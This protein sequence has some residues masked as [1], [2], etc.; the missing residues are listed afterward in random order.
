MTDTTP[1][2]S[3]RHSLDERESTKN[4]E[5]C[6]VP[7]KARVDMQPPAGARCGGA[8]AGPVRPGREY[9]VPAPGASRGA[10]SP[11][12]SRPVSNEPGSQP[13]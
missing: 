6:E 10:L 13:P 11:E 2:T 9:T 8:T 4:N 5:L 1:H 3:D 12:S 7:S